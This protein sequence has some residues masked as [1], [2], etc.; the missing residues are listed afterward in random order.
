MGIRRALRSATARTWECVLLQMM[1]RHQ[2]GVELVRAH[3]APSRPTYRR[4]LVELSIVILALGAVLAGV[5]VRQ[6]H[7]PFDS[8]DLTIAAGDLN[9]LAAAG[10]LLASQ[11][12][13]SSV[14]K[15]YFDAQSRSWH[16][17]V[18]AANEEL[19]ASPP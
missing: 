10:T 7:Q 8:K 16:E 19:R 9:S 15:S 6:A 12:P 1:S 17:K 14:T 13:G 18:E 3:D 11:S 2:A 5:L 4:I